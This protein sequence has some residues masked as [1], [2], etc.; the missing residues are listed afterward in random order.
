[1]NKNKILE[2]FSISVLALLASCSLPPS[3]ELANESTI[4]EPIL[5]LTTASQ[6]PHCEPEDELADRWLQDPATA[7]QYLPAKKH[8]DLW[9]RIEQGFEIPKQTNKRISAQKQWF[10]RNTDYMD[11]VS[12]R[13]ARYLHYVVT[14]LE[15]ANMPMELALLPI[16]ESAFDPFAYSHARASGM[17]QFIGATGKRYG[18]KQN[19]WYDG[20]RDIVAS[21]AGAIA[22]LR[23]LQKEF[24]GDWL[25][26]L[27]AY[28]TGEGNVRKAI[29]RNKRA[30][31]PTDF[32]SLRLPRE[33]RMYVPR[34]LAVAELLQQKN[35]NGQVFNP[36]T[37]EAYFAIVQTGSQLDLAQAAALGGLDME[38]IYLLNP[39]LNR[40]ATPPDG[41]HRLLIPAKNAGLFVDS[42]RS[43]PVKERVSWQRYTIRTGDTLSTIARKFNT[44]V[45]VIKS[46][47]KLGSNRIRVNRSLLIPAAMKK[48]SQYALSD[49]Q[50]RARKAARAKGSGSKIKYTVR[51]GDSLWSIAKQHKV[52]VKQLASWNSM[53]PR[54]PLR[55]GQTLQ[56]WTS[57]TQASSGQMIRKVGYKVRRGDS[58]SRIA[59]RFR[60]ATDDI[61]R[62][63]GIRKSS[64]LRPGQS[65]TLY[66]DVRNAI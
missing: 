20:R 40:W 31:K 3:S 63:N 36:I 57:A 23:D 15:E 13:S 48:D 56:I 44:S 19:W 27:A 59:Q 1:M 7:E 54:D 6:P 11:R 51:S 22:Y 50:R 10:L 25:L 14:E 18:M 53:V 38:E 24:N 61:S 42:L 17:W 5:E 16:V 26:A 35:S 64:I 8:A 49:S 28:N 46:A 29:R 4:P 65:L 37:D 43:L 52:S 30:G 32:W 33:T 39:G 9:T 62:W 55:K 66:V 21:T 58:L 12:R 2:A 60:V 41:P 47:N 34:L 45:S